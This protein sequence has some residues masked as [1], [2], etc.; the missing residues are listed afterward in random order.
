MR[1]RRPLATG[2][3]IVA[4]ARGDG[5]RVDVDPSPPIGLV[6]VAVQIAVMN[7]ADR[8]RIFVADLGAKRARLGKANVIRFGGRVAS[9]IRFVN[10]FSFPTFGDRY[11]RRALSRRKSAIRRFDAC[12]G[13]KKSKEII[14]HLSMYI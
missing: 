3:A 8:D 12:R 6:A 1:V 4:K 14:Y 5:Q 13:T 11:E 7:P 2:Y 9:R 10:G